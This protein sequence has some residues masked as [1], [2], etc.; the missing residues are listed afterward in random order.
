MLGLGAEDTMAAINQTTRTKMDTGARLLRPHR[1]GIHFF[2]EAKRRV[3]V[4]VKNL[5]S[6]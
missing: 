2:L 4:S 6:R 1:C 5:H 3:M